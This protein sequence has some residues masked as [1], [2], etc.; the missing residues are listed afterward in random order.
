[1]SAEPTLTLAQLEALIG[2]LPDPLEPYDGLRVWKN[3]ISTVHAHGKVQ[4]VVMKRR[5]FK[6]VTDDDRADSPHRRK[7]APM[8]RSSHALSCPTGLVGC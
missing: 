8:E 2:P 4:I 7:Y 1:M 5:V 6:M 3:G